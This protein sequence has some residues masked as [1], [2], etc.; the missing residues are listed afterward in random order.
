MNGEQAAISRR[1]LGRLMRAITN[2]LKSRVGGKARLMLAA[3][4]LLMLC[5]NGMNVT[6]SYVGRYFMTAI[7][8]RD[9]AAFVRY[10]WLYLVVFAGSTLVGV[11]FRFTEERLG[12]LWREWLTRRI[13]RV[14]IDRRLFLHFSGEDAVSN[15]DQR[16][17]ED[18]RQLTTTTLSFVL[19]ML[20]A[21]LTVLSFSGVLWNISPKLFLVAVVYALG[22]SLLTIWLGR[23][24]IRLN[25]RQ[26]DF[27]A[28]FRT[29]LI[30]I[31]RDG[32]Q[33]AAAGI[34]PDIK[35]KVNDRI[36]SVVSNLRHIIAIN[37]NLNFF[38]SGYNYLIQLIPV[39]I[40]APMFIRSEVEFGVIGQSAMA[41]AT[42]LGAFSLIITQFQ[43]ISSYASVV[44]RL[45]EFVEQAETA[46]KG[47][48]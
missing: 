31:Q 29:E 35:Q 5:I 46:G 12:L 28:D 37:R 17:T 3:L 19:M 26:S 23:P 8:N 20:N 33:I 1:T 22:G 27:E 4:L 43:A 6:N 32:E 40:V 21:T 30:R 25:Y 14:Y 45:S 10:A 16:M 41:F 34:E 44:A 42:L 24:L 39:L 48:S 13:T 9:S 7:E 36:D 15:P 18:V 2:F 38:T 11:L 47:G